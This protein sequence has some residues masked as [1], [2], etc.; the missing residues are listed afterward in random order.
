MT[1]SL[2]IQ[3]DHIQKKYRTS[4]SFLDRVIFDHDIIIRG[5]WSD[6]GTG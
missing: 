4:E 3:A 1:G 2:F 6:L 5:G